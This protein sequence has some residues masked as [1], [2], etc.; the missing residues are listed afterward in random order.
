MSNTIYNGKQ[1]PGGKG[2]AG[3]YQTIINQIPPTETFISGCLGNCAVLRNITPAKVNI[4]IDINLR[5]IEMWERIHK[6]SDVNLILGSFLDFLKAYRWSGKEFVYVDAPYLIDSRS[7]PK[8]M[9]ENEFTEEMHKEMLDTIHWLNIIST[10][11]KN[12]IRFCISHYRHKIYEHYLKGWRTID[13]TAQT[14]TGTATETIWMNYPTPKKL[15]DYSF[16]GN[17]Y[18]ERHRIKKKISRELKK[19]EEL[20]ELER[21]AIINAINKK[22]TAACSNNKDDD[23]KLCPDPHTKIGDT[24]SQREIVQL[25]APIS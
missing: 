17:N 12:K 7:T 15:H 3:V 21:N 20:N 6:R 4:G 13:F 16:V 14:R 22:F 23:I 18:R 19:L 8:K 11:K 9:Y 5:V 10:S 24:E 25:I 2:G 1:Y